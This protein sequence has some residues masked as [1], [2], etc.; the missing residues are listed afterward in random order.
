[1]TNACHSV[2]DFPEFLSVV[3]VMRSTAF[4]G[5]ETNYCFSIKLLASESNAGLLHKYTQFLLRQRVVAWRSR[6]LSFKLRA[7]GTV[8]SRFSVEIIWKN[9]LLANLVASACEQQCIACRD[10]SQIWGHYF[11]I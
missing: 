7:V 10:F 9:L 3:M 5:D 6:S 8:L 11:Q 1:M 2:L 4:I